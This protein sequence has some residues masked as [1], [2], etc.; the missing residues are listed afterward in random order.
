MDVLR[1]FES[2]SSSVWAD[3]T[4]QRESIK[5]QAGYG[6]GKRPAW[7]DPAAQQD[8]EEEYMEQE[9]D[10]YEMD[11][12]YENEETFEAERNVVGRS[13]ADWRQQKRSIEQF[14]PR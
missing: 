3:E 8:M 11:A 2:F 10:G 6:G 7:E 1:T 4:D 9:E 5:S 13:G 14:M 12:V